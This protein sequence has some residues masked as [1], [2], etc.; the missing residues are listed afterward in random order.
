MDE[1]L[2]NLDLKLREDMRL[3]IVGLQ[4][5]PGIT[6]VLVTHDQGE[7]LAVSDRIAIMDGGRIEQIGNPDDVDERPE[8]RFVARF[9]GTTNFIPGTAEIATRAGEVCPVRTRG[10]TLAALTSAA[11][12]A[13]QSVMA[14]VRPERLRIALH[15]D[16]KP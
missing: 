3:E 5:R 7:A 6:T 8:T 11:V 14:A 16:A 15:A 2:S 1:P 4:R 10:G 9:I 13:G 12:V